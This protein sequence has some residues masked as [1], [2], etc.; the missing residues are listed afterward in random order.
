M[1]RLFVES[2]RLNNDLVSLGEEDHRYLTRVLR[3]DLGADVT[4]FDGGGVEAD[5]QITRIGPRAIELKISERRWI[6]PEAKP[7]FTLLQ[8]LAKGDKLDLVV[9]KA[10]ELG[11]TRIIPITTERAIP[12]SFESSHSRGLGRMARWQKIAREASRQ[13]GRTSVPELEP[14]T[15][16]TTAVAATHKEALKLLLWEGERLKGIRSALDRNWTPDVT[17]GR[18][19]RIVLAV[20]PEG[21][22]SDEEVEHA[23][24]HGF[25]AVGL[26]PRILRTETA[27]LVA[28]SILGFALGDLG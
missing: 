2:E 5:A 19:A 12:R 3:L 27:A 15:S 1:A 17:S 8:G 4:L 7:E 10:T 23:Q 20:G 25:V 22:F 14:V 9:Q 13:S 26:G 21:G 11:V 16:F 24:A 18:P 28:L 6:A